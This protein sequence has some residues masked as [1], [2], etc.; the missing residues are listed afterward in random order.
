[1]RI[2]GERHDPAQGEAHDVGR[3]VV[4]VRAG[5]TERRNGHDDQR[6]LA[7]AGLGEVDAQ[8]LLAGRRP[9]VDDDVGSQ[10]PLGDVDVGRGDALL[11]GDQVRLLGLGQRRAGGDAFDPHHIGTEASQQPSGEGGRYPAFELEH[12]NT[13]KGKVLFSVHGVQ[14]YARRRDRSHHPRWHC[15]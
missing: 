6:R 15:R 14:H 12:T 8:L 4:A 1:M 10:H 5:L 13:I 11:A 3:L 2:A 9:V 7:A